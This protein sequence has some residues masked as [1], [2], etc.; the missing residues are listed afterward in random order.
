M[1]VRNDS[2]NRISSVYRFDGFCLSL[3]P[4]KCGEMPFISVWLHPLPPEG[5]GGRPLGGA[6]ARPPLQCGEPSLLTTGDRGLVTTQIVAQQDL[7][8]LR[9][10][11]RGLLGRD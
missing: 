8:G 2:R 9:F 6:G 3:F 1:N 5:R 10:T 4:W 7:V 11:L